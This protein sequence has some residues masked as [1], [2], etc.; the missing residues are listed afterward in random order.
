MELNYKTNWYNKLNELKAMH[1]DI[2]SLCEHKK[3]AY[4][5]IPLHFNVGDQLI[6]AGTEAFI[7][8]H[9]I[10]VV[11]RAF[12]INVDVKKIEKCDL[13]MF[14]GGGNFGDIYP[15]HQRL[16]ESLIE[17]YPSKRIII[18]PQTIHFSSEAEKTKSSEVFARHPDLYIYL[19]DKKSHEIAKAF[20]HNSSLMP[21]MAHSLHPLIDSSEV[22]SL[23]INTPK[24]I[25]L[26]RVDVEKVSA[27][28]KIHKRSFDWINILEPWDHTYFKYIKKLQRFNF[29]T[30][31]LVRSWKTNSDYL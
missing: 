19:R 18:L 14:H 16:R 3:V 22:E 21:D 5:D 13:I 4:I 7:K 25:N 27:E 20:S 11:Y 9:K 31:R 23:E 15:R 30:S 26:R 24:I 29:L 12:D 1:R 28:I 2:A 8:N 17:K 10:N 6:Y